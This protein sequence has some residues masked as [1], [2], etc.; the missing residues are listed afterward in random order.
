V[1]LFLPQAGP[2]TK[3]STALAPLRPLVMYGNS[4]TRRGGKEA[5]PPRAGEQIL[6]CDARPAGML[7]GG[8]F[9]P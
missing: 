6:V 5:L 2:K 9:E 4:L 3:G 1:G 8:G 7:R